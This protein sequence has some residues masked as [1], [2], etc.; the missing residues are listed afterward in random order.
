LSYEEIRGARA[1]G[2]LVLEFDWTIWQNL[3]KL[4]WFM[5]T[6]VEETD[7]NISL[8]SDQSNFE[9]IKR[10]DWICVGECTHFERTSLTKCDRMHWFVD[11]LIERLLL[12]FLTYQYYHQIHSTLVKSRN[13]D[14]ILS[15][16]VYCSSS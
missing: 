16:F 13:M 7:V 14:G 9:W 8:C 15:S 4:D 6:F 10:Y 3:F 1:D 2:I 12:S 5:F 11:G